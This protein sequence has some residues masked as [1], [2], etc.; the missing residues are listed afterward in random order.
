M[1]EFM[2]DLDNRER[3]PLEVINCISINHGGGLV[4]VSSSCYGFHVLLD[5][6]CHVCQKYSDKNYELLKQELGFQILFGNKGK[7]FAGEWWKIRDCG[8]YAE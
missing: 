1:N 5:E 6:P 3:L 7:K 2:Y 8:V 4:R